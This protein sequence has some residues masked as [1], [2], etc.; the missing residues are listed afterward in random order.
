MHS[1]GILKWTKEELKCM[2]RRT[3]KLLNMYSVINSETDIDRLCFKR[4]DGA[5]DHESADDFVVMEVLGK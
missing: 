1:S 2:G 3:R 4:K 5:R